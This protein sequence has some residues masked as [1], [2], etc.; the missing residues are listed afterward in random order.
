MMPYGIFVPSTTVKNSALNT[1][2]ITIGIFVPS[3]QTQLF[4]PQ[5]RAF[6]KVSH[7]KTE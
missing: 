2:H 4:Q 5:F 6:S 3:M 1:T 7:K